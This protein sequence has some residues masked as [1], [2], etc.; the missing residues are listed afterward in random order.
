MAGVI[1]SKIIGRQHAFQA[2][3]CRIISSQGVENFRHDGEAE[4]RMLDQAG[5]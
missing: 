1:G 5:Y 2:W 3:R 4:G